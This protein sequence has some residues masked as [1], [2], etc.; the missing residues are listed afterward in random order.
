MNFIE[1]PIN[2]MGSK[3]KLLPDLLPLFPKNRDTFIDLFTGG[4]SIYMNVAPFYKK[5]IANDLISD[6]ID[7]H[8]NLKNIEFIY[9]AVE[10]SLV[11]KES[12]EE[13]LKLRDSYNNNPTGEKLLAL[14]WAC[15]SNMMRFNNNMKFNST[16]GK[17]CFN[18]NKM[19]IY[20]KFYQND[21]NNVEFISGHFS[22]VNITNDC[23]VYLDPPY[24]NAE[25][26]YNAY[27][28]SSDEK[29]MVNMIDGFINEGILFGLSGVIND[30]PNPLFKYFE[31]RKD[32][33]IHYFGDMYQ[34]IAKRD[35]VNTEFY[36]TNFMED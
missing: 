13:Y 27:W 22:K 31:N 16:W 20:E 1:S 14:I 9:N 34:K 10:L 8:K 17:R 5:V 25:A 4:G 32:I 19:K 12:Q 15:N 36:I 29:L 24:S 28:K 33:K 18:V 30:K 35:K 6:L 26:G 3:Y 7:I 11:T 2:Y 21:Y 23:F